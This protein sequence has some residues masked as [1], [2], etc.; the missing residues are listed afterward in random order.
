MAPVPL[1][2]RGAR[3][4]DLGE[5]DGSRYVGL[6]CF[7]GVLARG[8]VVCWNC[9]HPAVVEVITRDS[10]KDGRLSHILRCIHFAEAKSNW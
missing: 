4:V 8:G 2:E 6:F 3:L 7:G 10:S 5:R 9:D 1:V